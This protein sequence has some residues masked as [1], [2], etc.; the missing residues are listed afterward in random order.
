M[1]VSGPVAAAGVI[2]SA[3]LLLGGCASG[4]ALVTSSSTAGP[5]TAGPSTAS[6]STSGSST[7]ATTAPRADL[8]ILAMGDSTV[9][10]HDCTDC[11]HSYPH[12]L[13]AALV[14]STGKRVDLID[15]TQHNALTAPQLLGEITND[16]WG[17]ETQD[18]KAP[19][20]RVAI[21]AADIITITLGAN[22]VPWQQDD[23][24]I[25][26]GAWA[27]RSCIDQKVTPSLLAL[28]QVID[29]IHTIRGAKPTAIRVTNFYNELI[30]SK[31][32]APDRP[33]ES[34]VKGLTGAKVFSDAL[35]D[36][37]CRTA[38]AHRAVCI[39]IYHGINGADGTKPLPSN[40]F[41]WAGHDRG[42]DQTFTMVAILKAGF[43]PLRL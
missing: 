19:D 22:D 3:A 41:R 43:A 11:S 25:C 36:G 7:S 31:D 12:Q 39:D 9:W 35:N 15:A 21:A 30:P 29:T 10:D 38:T 34:I 18:P 32:Y 13:R 24:P 40:W 42:Y 37:I 20:P 5:S 1:R 17:G 27:T 23:D 14:K 16:S 4:A 2:T 33:P 6:P 28:G 26:H 8:T